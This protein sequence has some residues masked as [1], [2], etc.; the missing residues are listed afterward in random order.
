MKNKLLL[1]LALYFIQIISTF[2][3]GRTYFKEDKAYLYLPIVI[4]NCE[5]IDVTNRFELNASFDF[6][7]TKMKF[8]AKKNKFIDDKRIK[9]EVIFDS[10]NLLLKI[11]K[12][13]LDTN[14]FFK[15][16]LCIVKK[17]T[18]RFVSSY[19][20]D[21]ESWFSLY[22]PDIN[23]EKFL[24]IKLYAPPEKFVLTCVNFGL[25]VKH[26]DSY[27]KHTMYRSLL[28]SNVKRKVRKSIKKIID[29]CYTQPNLDD[30]LTF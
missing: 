16:S 7:V 26:F 2:G 20:A 9:S 12:K 11:N 29:K 23:G 21:T 15:V 1:I 19:V 14:Y 30:P 10:K 13:D 8:Y 17:L 6:I 22:N 4:L 18:K 5:D 28:K 27:M 25:A 24:F 3:Q